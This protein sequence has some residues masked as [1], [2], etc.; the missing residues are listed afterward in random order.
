MTRNILSIIAGLCCSF[1][2]VLMLE[3]I[4]HA[5]N[6]L[7]D[8]IG[9]H[10]LQSFKDHIE[11]TSIGLQ[12]PVLISYAIGTFCGSLITT[13]IAKNKKMA[14]AITVGGILMG[15]GMYNLVSLQYSAWVSIISFIVFLPAAYLGGKVGLRFSKKS[16]PIH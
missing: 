12:L 7:P 15:L 16:R 6:P 3:G 1:I 2:I 9:V 8:N 10:D 5:L 13:L 11:S 14:K 4:N